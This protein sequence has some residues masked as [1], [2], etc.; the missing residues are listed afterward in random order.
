MNICQND[1]WEDDWHV[2]I[3]QNSDQSVK[4]HIAN[5]PRDTSTHIVPTVSINTINVSTQSVQSAYRSENL[6][7]ISTNAVVIFRN[8]NIDASSHTKLPEEYSRLRIFGALNKV[9]SITNVERFMKA[10][11]KFYEIE[12]QKTTTKT[13]QKQIDDLV[14]AI[15]KVNGMIS[16]TVQQLREHPGKQDLE[17]K[18]EIA[19]RSK[20]ELE[21]QQQLLL[22]SSVNDKKTSNK[23]LKE[24]SQ[25]ILKTLSRGDSRA[26]TLHTL[27]IQKV[28]P[29]GYASQLAE[30][31][32]QTKIGLE[33]RKYEDDLKYERK[34]IDKQLNG[35]S[36]LDKQNFMEVRELL[37]RGSCIPYKLQRYV[38]A[39]ELNRY[40]SFE[41]ELSSDTNATITLTVASD[42]TSYAYKAQF[43]VLGR[44][45]P[46]NAWERKLGSNT[47]CEIKTHGQWKTKLDRET[48]MNLPDQPKKVR[49][50]T[51]V[52]DIIYNDK[53]Y[54]D[55]EYDE[56]W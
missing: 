17:E 46:E 56:D 20:A 28:N 15:D 19:N 30:I 47:T 5:F 43:P 48:L 51:D 2:P 1:D 41:K 36:M 8:H 13:A 31:E 34:Q 9:W 6:D 22:R 53:D 37:R 4:H 3:Q 33:Q 49:N 42:S 7:E 40:L 55:N 35:Y 21:R 38:R 16:A 25:I 26:N 29:A 50:N 11:I 24:M 23:K 12:E 10:S 14:K 27:L 18:L 39:V 45:K 32:L 54:E 52:C 44:K